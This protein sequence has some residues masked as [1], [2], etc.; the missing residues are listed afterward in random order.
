ML[1]MYLGKYTIYQDIVNYIHCSARVCSFHV[2]AFACRQY[3]RHVSYI[4][5]SCILKVF[6]DVVRKIIQI[7]QN[8]WQGCDFD[9]VLFVLF[10]CCSLATLILIASSSMISSEVNSHVVSYQTL[11]RVKGNDVWNE[12]TMWENRNFS[13]TKI[14]F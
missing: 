12:G 3:P 2:T 4:N 11:L 9:F 5:V 8:S 1:Q 14:T 6:Q 7:S 10:S 13:V